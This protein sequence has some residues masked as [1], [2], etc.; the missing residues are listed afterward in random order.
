MTGRVRSW[1]ELGPVALT[2][3]VPFRR[4]LGLWPV[5]LNN[6]YTN[7]RRGG[8]EITQGASVWKEHVRTATQAA[9]YQLSAAELGHLLDPAHRLNL[10]LRYA[11]PPPQHRR[12]AS[13]L[14]K[15]A[16]DAICGAVGIDD[17]AK[18]LAEVR[19]RIDWLAKD[20]TGYLE[21][22][23]VPDDALSLPLAS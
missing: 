9:L 22:Q 8:R 18:R 6:A 15:L 2:F 11:F 16:E 13:N 4:E 12:D 1:P 20:E 5:S 7:G 3:V 17:G 19:C 21:V 23:L 10:S 14:I